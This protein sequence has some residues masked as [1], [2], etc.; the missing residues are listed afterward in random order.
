MTVTY[1]GV[2]ETV[3][4]GRQAWA[5]NLWGLTLCPGRV[6]ESIKL[7]DILAMEDYTAIKEE[8]LTELQT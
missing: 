4:W 7:Q 5:L 1:I 3:M 6:S 2:G 8:T